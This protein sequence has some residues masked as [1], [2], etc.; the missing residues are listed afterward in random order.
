[1]NNEADAKD[2]SLKAGCGVL[3]FTH[4]TKEFGLL[5]PNSKQQARSK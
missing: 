3:D 2:T 4:V 1:M 5:D